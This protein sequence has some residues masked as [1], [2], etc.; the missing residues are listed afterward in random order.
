MPCHLARLKMANSMR[1]F[2]IP[3]HI[4]FDN[5][6]ATKNGPAI[7]QICRRS[8]SS[9]PQFSSFSCIP[10]DLHSFSSPPSANLGTHFQG[11]TMSI[12]T[13]RYRSV[14]LSLSVCP[15]V[16]LFASLSIYLSLTHTHTCHRRIQFESL[17]PLRG[18]ISYRIIAART[19]E[20]S[21]IPKED[22]SQYREP[23]SWMTVY[24]V[25]GDP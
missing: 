16:Y 2:L 13:S 23:T 15:S 25:E 6:D 19:L 10:S 18:P 8:P 20:R 14:T 3:S 9:P 5:K 24:T 1:V 7:G 4:V 22:L 21:R 11:L 12:G 17:R